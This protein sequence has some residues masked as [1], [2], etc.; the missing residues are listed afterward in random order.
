M[1]REE[2]TQ[3]VERALGEVAPE[4]SPATLD[5]ERSLREQAEIDSFDFLN[6]LLRIEELTGVT[7]AEADYDRVRTMNGLVAY[8]QERAH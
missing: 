1:T 6:F 3:A 5:A 8:L 7:V 4:V 2:I